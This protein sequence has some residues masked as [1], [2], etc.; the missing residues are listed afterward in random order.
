MD[1]L[2]YSKITE[3]ENGEESYAPPVSLAQSISA[4]LTVQEAAATLYADDGAAYVIR[5][6]QTGTLTLGVDDI[7]TTAAADLTGAVV[8]D[9]GVLVSV[10]ENEGTPVAIGFRALKPDNR[11]RYFWIYRVKFGIPSTNL[12][13]KADT[14][15]FQ[16]PSI[17]GT[18]MRRN[19]VDG[20]GKHPWKAE[21]TDGDAGVSATT[22]DGWYTQVYEPVYTTTPPEIITITLNPQGGTVSPTTI[23]ATKGSNIGTLPTPTLSAN[24]FNGWYSASTGGTEVTDSTVI[25]GTI[26]TIYARWTPT[27]TT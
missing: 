9:N 22:I 11:Y 14:I 12:Q 19:R 16:T 4:G 3:N 17:E 13:T 20:M 8:D 5:D 27:T 24:T 21:V 18:I 1:K 25:D 6:F 7:G 26:T 10:S 23:Q 15:T 2:Y